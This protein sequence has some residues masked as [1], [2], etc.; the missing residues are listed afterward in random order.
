MVRPECCGLL[1]KGKSFVQGSNRWLIFKGIFVGQPQTSCTAALEERDAP[2]PLSSLF[3]AQLEAGNSCH[4]IFPPCVREK[5]ILGSPC[6]SE[7]GG[8]RQKNSTSFG[9]W[10]G[11]LSFGFAG[12][13][14]RTSEQRSLEVR[15]LAKDKEYD[16]WHDVWQ[17]LK[18]FLVYPCFM[19]HPWGFWTF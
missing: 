3:H 5:A 10:F 18:M 6:T 2:G 1:C 16:V 13:C 12:P 9:T 15:E 11:V 14:H 19:T 4:C 8:R 17:S 7:V